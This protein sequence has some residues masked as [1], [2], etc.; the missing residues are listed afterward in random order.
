M[1]KTL[2]SLIVT[3]L[4]AGCT[5]AGVK[6]IPQE[7]FDKNFVFPQSYDE[8]WGS[9]VEWFAMNNIPINSMEKDSGLISSNHGLSPGSSVINCGE[10]TGNVGL[11][12]ARFESAD[13]NINVLVREIGPE[14]TRATVNIFGNA[15]VVVRNGYGNIVSSNEVRCVSTGK[16]ENSY[17]NFILSN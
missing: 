2:T 11:Y 14:Q 13:S 6:N 8:V 4:L 1:K 16:L 12:Q 5:P 3:G 9:T 7:D 15:G 17:E 10:P